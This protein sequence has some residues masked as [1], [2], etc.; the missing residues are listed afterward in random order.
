VSHAVALAL[1]VACAWV[2]A[3]V[4]ACG[5]QSFESASKVDS[6]RLL[7]VKADKP[8]ARP[9]ETV[10]L[11]ALVADG[12]KDKT[13]PARVFWIPV[14][15][16]NPNEDAYFRC[17]A[18]PSSQGG[19][20]MRLIA[21]RGGAPA[22][23][24]PSLAAIPAGV[25]ASAAL[26]QTNTFSFVMPDDAV[27]PRKGIEPYGLAF[28][29]NVVCAGQ[30]R[31]ARFEPSGGPQQVPVECTDEQGN[32][33]PPSEYVIGISRVYS[34]QSRTNANPVLERITFNG[35]PVD[36]A[37][38][39]TVERCVAERQKDCPEQKFGVA[40]ADQSWED[41]PSEVTQGGALRE[42]IW[43][44]YFSDIGEFES[45]ARLLFDT[46]QGRV[47]DSDVTYR[48]PKQ[49]A[50]GTLWAVVRDNRGGASWLSMPV[51]VK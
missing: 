30:V 22:T 47:T 44:S 31:F 23:T 29:F 18:P 34:W 49:Q 33:L 11:E 20:G 1:A 36:P 26:V 16:L 9:G 40:I 4:S 8:Y 6:V 27:A 39:V 42:Q 2:W 41:N 35:A 5:G 24:I 45:E 46:R 37:V 19:P 12:R 32:R 38:G 25:D 21:A 17:F 10:T 48:A 14:V 28:V 13:R 50:S 51:G 7:A 3:G 43:V 15:C